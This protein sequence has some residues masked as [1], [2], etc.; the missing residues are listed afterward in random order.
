MAESVQIHVY[1][2][3]EINYY[4]REYLGEDEFLS[5]IAV[6]GEI[7]GYKAHSSGHVYFTLRE[8]DK[9]LRTVMFRR[10]AAQLE[11]RPRDGE[12]VVVLGRIGFYERDGSCQLYAEML[13][14]A[15]MGQQARSLEELKRRLEQEG[16]FDPARKQALPRLAL[17]IGVITAAD[18]AAWADIQRI[19]RNRCPGVRLCLYPAL[20]QGDNA[21]ASIVAQLLAA[22]A[23]GHDVL[24]CGR[25]GGADEDLA[26]F[27]SEA[28]VRAIAAVRTPL[29]SAVGHESDVTLADLAADVR[30]ATPTHAASLAV[31]DG[32]ALL[33]T[34]DAA[35][36]RMQRAL[37][38]RVLS[39]SVQLEQVLSS[40]LLRQP[41]RMLEKPTLQLQMLEQAL[42]RSMLQ[43]LVQKENFLHQAAGRLKAL[44]P[45]ATLAR[46]FSVALRADGSIIQD[47]SQ[48]EVDELIQV[49]LA[50]GSVDA[51][52]VAISAEELS[53]LPV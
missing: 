9:G 47:A 6:Q 28:V 22:D 2:V 48:L 50:Q 17:D 3:A 4:L 24:I 42:R 1:G 33:A 40:S 21:T 34:L 30:A 25:G 15:G 38:Q 20:V 43:G 31:P 27:N 11:W 32:A 49:R 18:S 23:A 29:I 10:Y 19:S 53:D 37:R 46:G 8:G 16:L 36:S 12:Q 41:Q 51:K 5:S 35:H 39:A 7:V 52:V 26:A 14:P 13:L 44:D 45:L